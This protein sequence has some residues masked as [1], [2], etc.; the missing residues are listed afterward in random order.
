[1]K[2]LTT[3][4][5]TLNLAVAGAYA[6]QTGAD[7]QQTP[8]KMTFSG[9]AGASTID[10]KQP[11]TTTGEEDLAGNG[12][13]GAF[14]FRFVNAGANGPQPSSTCSGLY[15]QSVA[16]GGLL[17]FQDGS[18]LNVTITQGGD[19]ID[20]VH[21]VAHCTRTF[22]INGGTG[23]FQNASGVLTLAETALPLLADASN[24]PVFFSEAGTLTGTI[25][26]VALEDDSRDG[27]R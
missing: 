25:S 18:M 3:I 2:H 7:G 21:M 5:L 13:L 10:L 23:R 26:G 19:C 16:G 4:A 12:T 20:L 9:S 15:F 22:K 6:Q 14:T 8:V 24:N 1:M 27:R 17:R 11:N